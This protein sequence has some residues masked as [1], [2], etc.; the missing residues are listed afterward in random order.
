MRLRSK[1]HSPLA[2]PRL[3]A[4][5]CLIFIGRRRWLAQ[6]WRWPAGVWLGMSHRWLG[7][8]WLAGEHPKMRLRSKEHSPLACSRLAADEC[9]ILWDHVAMGLSGNGAGRKCGCG[10][11]TGSGEYP[12]VVRSPL[13][14]HRRVL[15]LL[16]SI[17][18][19]PVQ[20]IVDMPRKALVR[21]LRRQGSLELHL[22]SSWRSAA[23]SDNSWSLA[24]SGNGR[25][26]GGRQGRLLQ[27]GGER[28]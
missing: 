24:R 3:A 25:L 2:C 14:R 4:D 8:A 1:E 19:L 7:T 5:E 28:C 27:I 22:A 11:L 26:K 20:S 17:A 9:L 13:V 15:D 23:H 12:V 18:R 6:R 16:A 10:W 21:L